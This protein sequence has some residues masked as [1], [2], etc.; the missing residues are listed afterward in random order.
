MV[1]FFVSCNYDK[2]E[3]GSILI[4]VSNT[5]HMG[6]PEKHFAG[7]NLW[8]VAPPTIFLFRMAIQWILFRQ[9]EVKCLS[10]WILSE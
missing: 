2:N 9:Q 3:K 8:E 10:P 1:L 5:E 6:D 4:I 7:N